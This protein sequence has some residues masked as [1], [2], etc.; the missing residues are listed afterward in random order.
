VRQA[1]L[2][3]LD[4]PEVHVIS[5]LLKANSSL[6]GPAKSDYER[7]IELHPGDGDAYRR[8]SAIYYRDNEPD[9]A[10][11]AIKKAIEVQPGDIR[12]HQ[13]LGTLYIRD[14]DYRAALPEFKTM[15]DLEPDLAEPHFALG[16]ELEFLGQFGEAETELRKSLRLQ[17]SSKAEHELG[18]I[19]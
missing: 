7:A 10:L 8:L 9:Q 14:G 18:T 3:N 11:D 1:E 17:D 19:L 12:N 4:I 13:Q 16:S 5:G 6:Y 2:R 15:V